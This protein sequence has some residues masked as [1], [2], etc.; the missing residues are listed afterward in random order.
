[1]PAPRPPISGPLDLAVFPPAEPL[2]QAIY[3]IIASFNSDRWD[4]FL[5]RLFQAVPDLA[6]NLK[7][8]FLPIPHSIRK[9]FTLGISGPVPKH[10]CIF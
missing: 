10:Y 7:T 4:F 9:V 1:M 8:R 3:E 6:P 5:R 2:D